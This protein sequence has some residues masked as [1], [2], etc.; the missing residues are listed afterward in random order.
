[1][2]RRLRHL[3][4]GLAVGARGAWDARRT[5]LA[6]GRMASWPSLPGSLMAGPTQ[7]ASD[8]TRP[9]LVNGVRAR[10]EFQSSE[11]RRL[12]WPGA[13]ELSTFQN[14]AAGVIIAAFQVPPASGTDQ[15]V[16]FFQTGTVGT[17]IGVISRIVSAGELSGGGGRRLDSD[18]FVNGSP[19]GPLVS[20]TPIVVD[21]RA[22]WSAGIVQAINQ[23]GS[24][25]TVGTGV[26]TSSGNT[27]NTASIAATVG[28]SGAA[29]FHNGFVHA[30]SV[31]RPATPLATHDPVFR[32]IQ[33]HYCLSF[34]IP[35]RS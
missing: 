35:Y 28:A 12:I 27:S 6:D 26:F 30:F 24:A 34:G 17:R 9:V 5:G 2:S 10:V 13:S 15:F 1:M 18:A 19:S 16:A 11:N 14:Q 25:R 21:L 33:Q 20:G 32:R 31:L 29:A 23:T 8:S 7:V 22:D 4:P 3:N